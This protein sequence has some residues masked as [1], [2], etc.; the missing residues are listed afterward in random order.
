MPKKWKT[1]DTKQIFGNRIFGFREDK[2]LSPKT[3]NTHRVLVMDAPTLVNIIPI[4]Y[5]FYIPIK[6]DLN[7]MNIFIIIRGAKI[8]WHP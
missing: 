6:R 1:L 7:N 5:L 2:V 3:E 8:I 4:Y